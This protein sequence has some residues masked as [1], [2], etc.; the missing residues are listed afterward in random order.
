MA[1][2]DGDWATA[3]IAS[4][5]AAHLH[6]EARKNKDLPQDPHYNYLKA[7]SVKR[8]KDAPRGVRPGL[9]KGQGQANTSGNEGQDP[10]PLGAGPSSLPNIN[11]S[12][13]EEMMDTPELFGFKNPSDDENESGLDKDLDLEE[14]E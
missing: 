14:H 10:G 4:Q 6:A 9:A 7:N 1:R 8:R 13:D 3:R 11:T 2:F 12:A 5:Y